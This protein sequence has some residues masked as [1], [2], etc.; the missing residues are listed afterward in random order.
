MLEV[1]AI[2]TEKRKMPMDTRFKHP[3][4]LC[5]HVRRDLLTSGVAIGA[6]MFLPIPVRAAQ[7]HDL[8]GKVR[9]NGR[10]AGAHT[11][12]KPGDH[13][14]AGSGAKAVFT[15]GTDAFLLHGDSSLKLERPKE[16]GSKLIGGFR[17][18]TGALLAVF[19]HGVR[20]LDTPK[21]TIGIRGT[22]VFLEADAEMTTL[23]TCYGDVEVQNKQS[24]ERRRIISAYHTPIVAH[25][26]E[27]GDMM[28]MGD[29]M[30]M[31]HTDDELI[32]LEKLVGRAS[33]ITLV[34]R[35]L[36]EAAEQAKG[37]AKSAPTLPTP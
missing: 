6:A 12:I 21:M 20:R 25:A 24:G 34:Q 14:A 27:L 33:P 11:V 19:D 1:G 18:L 36:K 2:V 5:S 29:G 26:Q 4:G 30:D 32:M 9:V 31:G 35:R 13:I 8:K 3:R 23:C 15:V 28:P 22:G 7:I 17:L 16:P 37:D 10:L